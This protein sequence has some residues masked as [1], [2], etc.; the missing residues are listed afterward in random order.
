MRYSPVLTFSIGYL[1]DILLCALLRLLGTCQFQA[2]LAASAYLSRG[3]SYYFSSI[4]GV[5]AVLTSAG[6]NPALKPPRLQ[7]SA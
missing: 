7:R 4:S 5:H 3:S 6:A 1:L 2:F